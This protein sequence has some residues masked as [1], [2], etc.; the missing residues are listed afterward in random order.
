MLSA[1]VE[2]QGEIRS[3]EKGVWWVKSGKVGATAQVWPVGLGAL[4]SDFFIILV[5]FQDM[6]RFCC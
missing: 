3:L 1:F 5:S 2:G 4:G 6:L